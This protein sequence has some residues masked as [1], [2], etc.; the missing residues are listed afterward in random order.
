MMRTGS[1]SEPVSPNIYVHSRFP[2]TVVSLIERPHFV[3]FFYLKLV[4]TSVYKSGADVAPLL[5]SYCIL[6]PLKDV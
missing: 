1:T 6:A 4:E 2:L 5:D 3:L